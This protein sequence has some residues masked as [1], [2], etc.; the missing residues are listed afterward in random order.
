[1]HSYLNT[2]F[3]IFVA[4]P[5]RS[6][7]PP[8]GEYQMVNSIY[9]QLGRSVHQIFGAEGIKTAQQVAEMTARKHAQQAAAPAPAPSQ[10]GGSAADGTEPPAIPLLKSK[11]SFKVLTECPL[12]VM[13]LFQLYPKYIKANIPDLIPL[14]IDALRL[15]PTLQR[16]VD[17]VMP[18]CLRAR[19][20]EM[21]ACQVGC[22]CCV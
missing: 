8:R 2:R 7:L 3:I 1:M 13:L 14:M 17:G 11:E 9:R 5:P 18:P 21:I 4:V 15:A 22:D 16:T 12:I 19:Y 10:G 6:P 20:K